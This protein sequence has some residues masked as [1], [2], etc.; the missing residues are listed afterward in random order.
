[1]RKV[2]SKRTIQYIK[3]RTEGFDDDFPCTNERFKL[4]H[5]TNWFNLFVNM[6][7]KEIEKKIVVK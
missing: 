6:H 7:N 4:Q 5:I 2:L 3:D 1:M